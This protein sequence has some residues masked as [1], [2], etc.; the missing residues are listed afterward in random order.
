MLGKD[1]YFQSLVGGQRGGF[2][3]K[4]G[5]FGVLRWSKLVDEGVC[6]RCIVVLKDYFE[7]VK[8][9]FYFKVSVVWNFM[10]FNRCL[11]GKLQFQ[12]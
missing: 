5:N 4:V 9:Y 2:F 3:F 1:G 7:F 8:I 6:L 12:E 10:V 11:G